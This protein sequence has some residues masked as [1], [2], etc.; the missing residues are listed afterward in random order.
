LFAVQV[1]VIGLTTLIGVYL[2]QLI[3]EDLLTRQTLEGEAEHYWKLYEINGD[4]PLPDTA[5]M[6][7][8]FRPSPQKLPPELAAFEGNYDRIE[9][10]GRSVLVHRSVEADKELFLIFEGDQVSSLAFY[11]GTLPLSIVLLLM[12][13]LLFVAYRWSQRA[14]SPVVRLADML[15]T[16]DIESG[17]R[18]EMDFTPLMK[19]ADSEVIAMIRAVEHFTSRLN[20]A[21]ERERIFTR[22]AGHELRT[23]LAVFKGSLDL[24]DRSDDR[25]KHD[26]AALN[27][28]RSMVQNMESLLETLLLLAR[29]EELHTPAKETVV[30]EIVLGQIDALRDLAEQ[31]ENQVTLHEEAELGLKVPERVVEI[32]VR[33]LLRNSLTYTRGGKVDVTVDAQGVIVEDTGVGMNKQEVENAFEPFYRAEQS[34]EKTVGHGLGLSIVRRLVRQFGWRI[35]VKSQPGKGTSIGII[36]T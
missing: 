31:T 11:F 32:I 30:N 34:R 6:Q 3:V 13:V 22:D 9:L 19:D 16:I 29:E 24:M 20:A 17:N 27:R 36:F 8:Y 33:N 4:Q 1:L 2:T 14:L 28:M 25:P 23:P 26:Q 7:G 35:S 21:I 15:E 5:N 18:L 10:N 12:Y